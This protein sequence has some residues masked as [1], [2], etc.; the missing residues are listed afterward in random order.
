ML[1]I[2]QTSD[3]IVQAELLI[4]ANVDLWQYRCK[5]SEYF[6]LYWHSR[7]IIVFHSSAFFHS[8]I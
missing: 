8:Y 4:D 6:F 5:T 1:Q 3:V 2:S 7:C